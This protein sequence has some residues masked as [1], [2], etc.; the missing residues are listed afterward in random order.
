MPTQTQPKPPTDEDPAQ[1]P[2]LVIT[3]ADPDAALHTG[4]LKGRDTK[5]AH[6]PVKPRRAHSPLKGFF[7]AFA[8]NRAVSRPAMLIIALFEAGLA[9]LFWINSPF[10]VLPRPME[11]LEALKKLWLTMGLGQELASSFSMN[12][13]ALL[14]SS[15][16]ALGLAYSTVFPFMRPVVAAIA[17]GRFL[18]TI[19]FSWIF[20]LYL[21]GGHPLKTAYLVFG[22]TVF[23]VTSMAAVI[24]AIP[25]GEFDHAR[26]LQM[27]E[28]RVVWE[29]VI[30]GTAD[31][32]FEVLRQ[33]AAI[34]WMMLTL[35]EGTVRSG[36]GLGVMLLNLNKQVMLAEVFAVQ[37]LILLVGM[38]Q[39]S[40]IGLARRAVC[41]YADLT[42]ERK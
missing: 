38:A 24:A 32:A 42:L 33:N 15:L 40:A 13:Q 28:W 19:G 9:L 26:T 20:T 10:K 25:K 5:E 12:V 8:P 31:K 41:P 18:S 11:V 39:D 36:G 4:D 14:I 23:Y 21:G 1:P 35:V 29:V 22:I 27:S 37:I 6:V 2:P 16:L 17:R 34:G 3:G 30:L 7:A